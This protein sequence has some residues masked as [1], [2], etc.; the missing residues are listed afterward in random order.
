MVIVIDKI[1]IWNEIEKLK[2]E[3]LNKNISSVIYRFK[4]K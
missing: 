3:M 1:K 4:N 2:L